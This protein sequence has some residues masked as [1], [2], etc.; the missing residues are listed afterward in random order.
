MHGDAFLFIQNGVLNARPPVGEGPVAP[1]LKRYRVGVANGG[2]IVRDRTF[3][4][5]AIEQE[6]ERSQVA[7]DIDPEV[8]VDVNRA[9]SAG[10]YPAFP[11]RSL[12]TGFAPTA[13]AETEASGKID[14]LWSQ[15][16]VTSL[17]YALTNN[18]EAGDAYNSGGLEDA[19]GRGNSFL[20]DQSLAG[21]WTLTASPEVAN[22]LRAQVSR[23]SAVLRT[24]QAAGPEMIVDGLADFGQP[25]QGNLEYREDHADAADT[26]SWNRGRHL[27][28]MGGT[29]TYVH[30][31]AVNRYGQG[32][33]FLFSTLTDFLAGQPAMYRQ[34][35]GT[36]GAA[37]GTTSYG[38]FVQDH[39]VMS[40]HLTLDAGLRYDF[41]QLPYA[42]QPDT[43]NLS[44]RVGLAF[45]PLSRLVLRAGYEIFFDRYVLSALDRSIVGGL[46]GF[47]QVV[48]GVPDASVLRAVAGGSRSLPLA[49]VAPS[50]YGV[51]SA[52]ATPYSQQA[53]AGLQYAPAKDIT[54]SASYLFVRGLRLTRTRNI[55]LFPPVQQSTRPLFSNDRLNPAFDSIYQLED[56][57]TSTYNGLSFALRV[58]KEDFTLD[59]S[60]T[61]SKVT[62]DASTWAEQPQNPYAAWQ[63]R[64]LSLFDVR[65][66]FVLSGLFDLPIGD[67]KSTAKRAPHSFWVRV[68]SNIEMA[69]ILT[70][71]G[72]R[73]ADP[74]TGVDS[75][76]TLSYYPPGHR[77]SAETASEFLLLL[78]LISG[79]SRRFLWVTAAILTSWRNPSI[80]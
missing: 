71:E 64:A 26:Y 23:R 74:L 25:Y 34:I 7:G 47:E 48:E 8:A 2:A 30:E 55:N 68:I 63:D 38:G 11:I 41:E 29:L 12:N 45:S 49:G 22:E 60:Y 32:G 53:S 21:S 35:F 46:Q 13:R 39:W 58:M 9:L 50:L 65:N 79:F 6:H 52:L 20:R 10:L 56:S 5:A 31:D 57:A 28:Q 18:R 44:P 37:F 33:L 70:V 67:E 19:S 27:V 61:F 3:Y 54:A 76:G 72:A 17:R 80:C 42:F 40:R 4:Y 73:P 78:R 59:T 16:S 62:D 1:D 75:Y 14:Q 77:V 24:N 15:R 43:R 69:P 66:R 51:D 36:L